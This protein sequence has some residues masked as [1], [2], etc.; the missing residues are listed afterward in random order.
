[1]GWEDAFKNPVNYINPAGFLGTD[2]GKGF[3]QDVWGGIEDFGRGAGGAIEDAT[4]INLGN[5]SSTDRAIRAQREAGD[6]A[7]TFLGDTYQDQINYLDPWAQEGSGAMKDLA[8]G[9]FMN[10]WQADP[11][12][13]FRLQEGQKALEGSAAAKGMLNSSGTMKSLMRYGQ[14]LASQEYGNI[15]NREYNRLSQLAGFGQNANNSR[16]NAT[17]NYG[18]N[19]SNNMTGLGNATAAASIAQGQTFNQFL[20]DAMK[21]AGNAAATSGAGSGAGA[22]GVAASDIRVK[23]NIKPVAKE[24]VD[25]LQKVLKPYHYN[26]INNEYGSGNWVGVMAQDLEKTKLGKLCVYKNKE[27]IRVV[28]MQKLYGVLVV[29]LLEGAA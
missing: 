28:D 3:G 6:R 24:D 15:Y 25:E 17:A 9:S 19:V 11:G 22:S 16:V 5:N 8:S 2:D 26:Y 29:S 7:N 12:Y 18:A 27:G 13:Q 1:M 10:N 23:E 14:G 4:G 20:S 21:G